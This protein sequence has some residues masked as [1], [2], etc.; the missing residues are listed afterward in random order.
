MTADSDAPEV[1]ETSM[2]ADLFH[3]LQIFSESSINNVGKYLR[4]SSVLDASLSVQE[5]LGN[6]VFYTNHYNVCLLDITHF[7]ATTN[8]PSYLRVGL[9]KM[10][11]ILLTSDSLS[12]P[13]LR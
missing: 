10:S 2:L 11:Q 9:A 12:S 8:Q 7:L 3:A 5:P 6:A 13:A 4:V 1:T